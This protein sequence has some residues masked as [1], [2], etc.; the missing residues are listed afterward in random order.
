MLDYQLNPARTR[1]YPRNL[2]HAGITEVSSLQHPG[3]R[4]W[5]LNAFAFGLSF[6]PG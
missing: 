1:K 2:Y 5:R 3:D 6:G 4:G